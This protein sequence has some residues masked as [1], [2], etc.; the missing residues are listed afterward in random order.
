MEPVMPLEVTYCTVSSQT[1]QGLVSLLPYK[2]S[3]RRREP[4]YDT[5][6]ARSVRV[7]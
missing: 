5:L 2:K 6:A 4:V 7:L 3:S 1:L